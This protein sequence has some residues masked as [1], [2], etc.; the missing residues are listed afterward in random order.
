MYIF[1]KLHLSMFQKD[2][3]FTIRKEMWL[4]LQVVLCS[5]TFSCI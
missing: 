2:T 4:N 5:R 3:M 1:L